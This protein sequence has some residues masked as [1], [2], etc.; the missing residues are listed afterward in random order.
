[1]IDF[2]QNL[3]SENHIFS[4]EKEVMKGKQRSTRSAI[5]TTRD[6]SGIEIR[7]NHVIVKDNNTPKFLVFPGRADVYFINIVVSDLEAASTSLD[8]KGFEKIKDGDSLSV[9]KTLYFW[10]KK[11]DIDLSPSQIHVFSS[12]VKS[13]ESLRDSGTLISSVQNDGDYKNIV[14]TIGNTIKNAATFN[15]ISSSIF[16]IAGIVGKYLGKVEDRP[17]LSWFQSFTDLGGD[18]DPLGETKKHAENNY[19]AM[20]LALIVRDKERENNT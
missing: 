14:S 6:I 2:R 11:N 7:L 20:N 8:L 15:V 16:S 1:M 13:K 19:A 18:F 12:I 9:D 5:P 4:G 10:K 3:Y 17:L